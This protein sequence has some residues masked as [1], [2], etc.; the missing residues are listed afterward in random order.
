MQT[1]KTTQ[2]IVIG[3]GIVGATVAANLALKGL[4]VSLIEQETIGGNGAT[5]FS[6]A[7]F[8]VHDPDHEIA[9]LTRRSVELMQES[10][11]G[12]IFKKMFK[13]TGIIYAAELNQKN[14]ELIKTSIRDYSDSLYP[15]ELISA[16]KA[17]ELTNGCYS[18]HNNRIILFEPKGGFGYIRN[19]AS[20]LAQIVRD[21][22][23]LVLENTKVHAITT[24]NGKA[25]VQLAH[26]TIEAD[27]IVLAIGA[28]TKT[29][30]YKLPVN[31]KSIPLANIRTSY[32]TN[33]PI[34]DTET[35]THIVP[36]NEYYYQAGSK[37]R[38][39][40]EIPENIEY[41]DNIIENDIS[42]RLIKSNFKHQPENILSIIKGYDSY[43]PDER[44]IL[45][46]I[47]EEKKCFVAAGFCGIGYKIALAVS[48]IITSNLLPT[49]LSA[50]FLKQKNQDFSYS[51]FT[52]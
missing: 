39:A 13:Q 32:S 8:R 44:P 43:T 42:E 41:N 6:G 40:A 2:I 21:T 35:G 3:G 47:D 7:L 49:E 28:W 12:K 29:L 24:E 1:D 4:N 11:V 23:N 51:R 26:S 46:F 36:L 20:N 16:E 25:I 10:Q 50:N 33:M 17:F 9:K 34:I 48:E 18:K 14:I 22:G 5:K 15:L 45:D 27:Y 52:Y 37:I 30:A 31:A 19:T 38:N